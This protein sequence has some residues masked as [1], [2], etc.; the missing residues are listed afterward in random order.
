MVWSYGN[1]PKWTMSWKWKMKNKQ[2][3][4]C[5]K[6]VW[7]NEETPLQFKNTLGETWYVLSA[8]IIIRYPISDRHHTR[9]QEII[10][11]SHCCQIIMALNIVTFDWAGRLR[12]LRLSNSWYENH[13]P[14]VLIEIFQKYY[15][16]ILSLQNIFIYA[17]RLK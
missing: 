16:N 5:Y 14:V 9:H 17:P 4:E 7:L 2:M 1:P 11:L 12:E 10:I 6:N 15:T 3:A 8:G 13:A